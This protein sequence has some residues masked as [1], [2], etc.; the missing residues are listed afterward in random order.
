MKFALVLQ[1]Q[2]SIGCRKEAIV[3][4]HIKFLRQMPSGET[5][6]TPENFLRPMDIA[7]FVSGF[8][9]FRFRLSR[10]GAPI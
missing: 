4:Q 3:V 6:F 10:S 8:H 2:G 9:R 1:R 5:G 7:I